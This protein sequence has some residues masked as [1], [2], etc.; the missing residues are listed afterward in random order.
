MKKNKTKKIYGGDGNV[1]PTN[2]PDGEQI[3]QQIKQD[4]ENKRQNSA[5]A[6]DTGILGNTV[7]LI[8]G[9]TTNGIK[10]AGKFAGVDLDN[11]EN[12]NRQFNEVI[13]NS[14]IIGAAALQAS[15]P[16]IQPLVD[17]TLQVAEK[18]GSKIAESGVKI[19]L[20]TAE[21]IPGVGV[22]IGTIRS[23]SN[24]G[25]AF[26]A[27]TDAFA[28]MTTAYADVMNATAKN[29]SNQVQEAKQVG[30][31]TLKSIS[32]FNR[33]HIYNTNNNNNNSKKGGK[34]VTRKRKKRT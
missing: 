17:K 13:S 16:F 33:P 28:E 15:E 21:E 29:M 7:T 4:R 22:L 19:L 3:L 32:E 9:I 2:Q 11:P 12:T 27:S 30:G 18:S 20:N 25:E 6:S 10:R 31:R 8:K 1:Q 34:K 14:A 5:S 23:L 24:A 26:T